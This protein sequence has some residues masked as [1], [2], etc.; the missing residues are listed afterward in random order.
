MGILY[1]IPSW[2]LGY[3]V[4]FQLVF[5]IVSVLV[6]VYAYKIYKVSEEKNI[7]FF[8]YAFLLISLSYI[9]WPVINTLAAFPISRNIVAVFLEN[10][11]LSDA[12]A[13]YSHIVLFLA[14]LV[15]LVY[16]T[17]EKKNFRIY[18]LLSVLLISIV[19]IALGKANLIYLLFSILIFLTLF[20]Y[21]RIYIKE[22]NSKVLLIMIAFAFLFLGTVSLIFSNIL[23]LFYVSG[24]F[25]ILTAY[26]LILTRLVIN[27]RKQKRRG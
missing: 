19:L 24:H 9:L 26:V 6:A 23:D 20:H 1:K 17:L 12:V 3:S 10:N 16:S 4:L 25:F 13:I 5:A 15:T 18:I 21:V 11:E 7:K 22:K 2:F 8:G 14:G 27:Y